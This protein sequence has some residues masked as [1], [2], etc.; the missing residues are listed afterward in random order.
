MFGIRPSQLENFYWGVTFEDIEMQM[1]LY[2]QEKQITFQQG[3]ELMQLMAKSILGS[4][5]KGSST[6]D[7]I[8]AE[9]N[10]YPTL[11]KL[12]DVRAWFAGNKANGNKQ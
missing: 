2:L 6:N 12:D 1:K 4:S 3:F 7:T 8:Q 11:N 5:S 9:I 10:K